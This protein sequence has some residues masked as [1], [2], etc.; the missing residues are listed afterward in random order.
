[1]VLILQGSDPIYRRAHQDIAVLAEELR[2]H[3]RGHTVVRVKQAPVKV[4]PGVDATGQ[5]VLGSNDVKSGS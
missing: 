1:M 4:G 2:P 3:A 5:P